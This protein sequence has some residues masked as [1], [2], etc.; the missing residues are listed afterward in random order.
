MVS[1]TRSFHSCSMA[2]ARAYKSVVNRQIK[3][4]PDFQVGDKKPVGIYIPDKKSEYPVY[5]YGEARIFKRADHGLF[6]GQVI[7][8]GNQISEMKNKSRRT[9]LPNVITKSIWSE[10]L[11]KS[12]KMRLT[13]RVLK[14][15]TKEG[16]LD[17]Y[18]IKDKSARVKELGLFG[19]RLKYDVLKAQEGMKRPLNFELIEG[20]K[21]YYNGQSQGK[22]VQITIGKRK[23]L[24]KLFYGVRKQQVEPV[25]VG[26]FK[27]QYSNKTMPEIVELCDE[28][29]VDLG[30]FNL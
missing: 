18:L 6:G 2:A 20:K 28:F 21:V 19:W 11:G 13:A 30:E 10:S 22:N 17:N 1:L 26:E 9:W 15:I 3:Q 7:G 5:P 8:F 4:V 25:S 27:Q 29:N 14:T 12:I 23:L 24:E 16:G